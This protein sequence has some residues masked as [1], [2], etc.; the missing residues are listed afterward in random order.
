[1][2]FLRKKR[3]LLLAT[4]VKNHKRF[5][6]QYYILL[7]EGLVGWTFGFAW[8]TKEGEAWLQEHVY[9]QQ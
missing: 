5:Y 9:S 6:S 2:T 8:L 7:N 3:L 4:K 1:M